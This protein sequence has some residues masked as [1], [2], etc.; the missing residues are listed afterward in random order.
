MA[1]GFFSLSSFFSFRRLSLIVTLNFFWREFTGAFKAWKNEY[2]F[3]IFTNMAR[4]VW[5][6][7]EGGSLV[8]MEWKI[9]FLLFFSIK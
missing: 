3:E 4:N 7:E 5:G 8:M 9:G 1:L 6:Y 2:A